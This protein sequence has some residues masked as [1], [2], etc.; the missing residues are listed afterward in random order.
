MNVS[1]ALLQMGRLPNHSRR[2][3]DCGVAQIVGSA[4]CARYVI[5]LFM[6][7]AKTAESFTVIRGGIGKGKPG[8]LTPPVWAHFVC[9]HLHF[10]MSV[11]AMKRVSCVPRM[12]KSFNWVPPVRSLIVQ[13]ACFVLRDSFCLAILVSRIPARL[14][15]RTHRS[16]LCCVSLVRG[17]FP[18][19]II[20]PIF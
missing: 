10:I 14:S 9:W 7:R 3:R 1:A 17:A 18:S 2:T 16:G 13:T 8:S 20:H 15:A 19:S 6:L 5:I 11:G 12:C 4:I